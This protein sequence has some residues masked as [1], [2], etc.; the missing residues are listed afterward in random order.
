MKDVQSS[1]AVSSKTIALLSALAVLSTI[2]CGGPGAD[3][4][5]TDDITTKPESMG[6]GL[7]EVASLTLANGNTVAFYDA[8]SFGLTIERGK[9]PTPPS[10]KNTEAVKN[11]TNGRPSPVPSA[12]VGLEERVALRERT[13]AARPT[14]DVEQLKNEMETSAP[15]GRAAV[16]STRAD[17]LSAQPSAG[18]DWCDTGCCDRDWLYDS[19]AECRRNGS[20]DP[21]FP[22]WYQH[23]FNV[24][25][26][27]SLLQ[28]PKYWIAEAYG[29]TCGA[30]GTSVFSGRW[31]DDGAFDLQ[32]PE[33][34]WQ[35]AHVYGFEAGEAS[36]MNF[37]AN[38]Q[39]NQHVHSFCAGY[40]VS[41]IGAP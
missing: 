9:P 35:S 40:V 41:V 8:Q 21:W 16:D 4:P 17:E 22:N 26:G 33:G 5:A 18:N 1:L 19:F 3:N 10:L 23:A 25:Y 36:W 6:S 37:W 11:A 29:M 12:L 15:V 34:T 13:N 30:V 39:A 38:D 24:T 2:G 7:T 14:Q 32:V 31:Q 28:Q 20:P 27:W